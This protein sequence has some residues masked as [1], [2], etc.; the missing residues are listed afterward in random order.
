MIEESRSGESGPL[1]GSDRA[2]GPLHGVRVLDL[3]TVY[4]APTT[5]ML[6]GDYGAEVVKVEHPRGDQARGPGESRSGG[7]HEGGDG[8]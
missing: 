4:A 6:L 1:P 2:R 5:A 3:G 8:G 7:N